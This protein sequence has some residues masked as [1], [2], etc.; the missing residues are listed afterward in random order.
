MYSRIPTAC[1]VIL[2]YQPVILYPK[3]AAQISES[4]VQHLRLL[5]YQ[6]LPRYCAII[7]SAIAEPTM[8]ISNLIVPYIIFTGVVIIHDFHINANKTRFLYISIFLFTSPHLDN[9]LPITRIKNA[10][11]PRRST[12][13]FSS[14]NNFFRRSNSS[15]G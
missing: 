4:S 9:V 12:A 13:V 14:L 15:K 7:I 8:K 10:L 11:K 2:S 5:N 6:S 1:S 3:T